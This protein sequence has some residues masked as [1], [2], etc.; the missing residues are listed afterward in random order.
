METSTLIY[1]LA[2]SVVLTVAPGP[3]NIYLLTKSIADG[4]KSGV[5]LTFGLAS[6][7]IFHTFL[8]IVGVAALVQN[9]P[10]TFAAL[11]FIGAAY[12]LYLAKKSFAD[13]GKL[14]IAAQAA[15][16]TK[17]FA[18]YRRGVLMNALN[19]K[20]LLFFLAFLPQFVDMTKES[21]PW[22]IALLGFVFAVQTIV[23]FSLIAVGAGKVRS[24]ILRRKNFG[25]IIA[26]TQGVVLTVIALM[27]LIG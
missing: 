8:F 4:A 19:P 15:D 22:Q 24:F 16:K 21:Y 11:K 18:L 1:F 25:K 5:A 27:L 12:L 26:K 17:L 13:N 9:S 10:V 7:I 3:D 6:G 23:I 14:K 20:V 2:A